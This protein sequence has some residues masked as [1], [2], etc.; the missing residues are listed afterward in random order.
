MSSVFKPI[1]CGGLNNTA[2]PARVT[3]LLFTD[4]VGVLNDYSLSKLSRNQIVN[5]ALRDYFKKM[6]WVK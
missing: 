1:R 4:V 5:D 6:E 3:V 2:F